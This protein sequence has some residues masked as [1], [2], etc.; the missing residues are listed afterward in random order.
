[1]PLSNDLE[2]VATIDSMHS[3]VVPRRTGQHRLPELRQG[4]VQQ[5]SRL[6]GDT[7][8]IRQLREG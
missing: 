3:R 2:H 6:G 8:R 5:S 1:M 4:G 7:I